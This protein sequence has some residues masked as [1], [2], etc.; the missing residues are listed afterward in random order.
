MEFIYDF[1]HMTEDE[2]RTYLNK[3][4]K[5]R[6]DAHNELERREDA[7]KKELINKLEELLKEIGKLDIDLEIRSETSEVLFDS[8]DLFNGYFTIHADY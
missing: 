1:S 2:I 8:Y 7:H 5:N 6:S 4:D 3:V